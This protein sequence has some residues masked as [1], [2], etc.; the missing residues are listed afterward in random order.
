LYVE[1]CILFGWPLCI[2]KINALTIFAV[3]DI[4]LWTQSVWNHLFFI[5]F[6]EICDYKRPYILD[7]K[8]FQQHL[9][10]NF[11]DEVHDYSGCYIV[12]TAFFKLSSLLMFVI[13]GSWH[14]WY[15]FC[16][17]RD[18]SPIKIGL[19]ERHGVHISGEYNW[20]L[21]TELFDGF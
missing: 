14:K 17:L 10:V 20:I 18:A 12:N 1:L 19:W 6:D 7:T 11:C 21:F 5:V 15:K 2:L 9:F 13:F 8:G 3:R 4:I 16:S